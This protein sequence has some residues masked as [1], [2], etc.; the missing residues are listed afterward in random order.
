MQGKVGHGE[1]AGV[2]HGLG[3]GFGRGWNMQGIT[4]RAREEAQQNGQ[5]NALLMGPVKNDKTE[6]T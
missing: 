2:G 6:Q 4:G 3:G 1:G 5:L